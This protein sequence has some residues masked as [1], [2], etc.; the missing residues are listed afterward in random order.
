[1]AGLIEPLFDA[2]HEECRVV[3]VVRGR[4]SAEDEDQVEVLCVDRL[5]SIP[6][7]FDFL[8]SGD[9]SP[10]QLRLCLVD[11][12]WTLGIEHQLLERSSA[13]IEEDRFRETPPPEVR[14]VVDNESDGDAGN[15]QSEDREPLTGG[16]QDGCVY[17]ADD[18]GWRYNTQEAPGEFTGARAVY[19]MA[20][21]SRHGE[22][23]PPKW[24]RLGWG[25]FDASRIYITKM[26]WLSWLIRGAFFM[27][28]GQFA[29]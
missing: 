15:G 26:G 6:R 23:S 11:G 16:E 17:A 18:R 14:K 9:S 22:G 27:A 7:A 29:S 8:F 19:R 13:G 20:V 2:Q 5:D 21:P 28:L 10:G 4:S 24:K 25:P 12:D 3:R 1:M